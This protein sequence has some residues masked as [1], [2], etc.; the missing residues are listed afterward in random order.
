M[1][2]FNLKHS[3]DP[4]FTSWLILGSDIDQFRQMHVFVHLYS[5]FGK[6]RLSLSL[7]PA[8]AWY[9]SRT[10]LAAPLTHIATENAPYSM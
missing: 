9:T 2:K 10:S 1:V 6:Y 3:Y 7:R 8:R 5:Y 4:I